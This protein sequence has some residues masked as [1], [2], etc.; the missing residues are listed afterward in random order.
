MEVIVIGSGMAGL[1]AAHELT[2][3][4]HRVVVVDKGRAPGGRMA[5]RSLSGSAFD[6]GAQHFSVR[7][8]EFAARTQAWLAA[9]VARV[10]YGAANPAHPAEREPRYV[11]NGAMRRIPEHL[12]RG[13]DVR[14]S[15]TVTRLDPGEGT[16]HITV[17]DTR[18]VGDAVVLTPPVPQ[19]LAILE[20]SDIDL[21]PGLH[22]LLAA[23]TY[24]PCIALMARLDRDPGLTDGHRS[25]DDGPI[26]WIADNA[27]KGVSP[28]PAVTVHSTA[29]FADEH[30][31]RPQDWLPE[32]VRAT[33]MCL[34][35]T[36]LSATAHLW[37]YAQPR[38][39]LDVGAV[40]VGSAP[41]VLAG[42]A[43]SGARVEGAFLSGLAA[44]ALLGPDRRGS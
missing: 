17:G 7:T 4:G 36:I 8:P 44:A 40:R 24:D 18:L 19:I 14:Q 11:G 37:R 9:G 34:P 16:I 13:L 31:D 32:L 3:A 27:H 20:A 35:V 29:A 1:T 43:F 21:S 25:F 28:G 23:V 2:D 15:I 5:T 22:E 10:W 26:A 42:E 38:R 33:E 12:A 6:H 39:T 41:I 30:I